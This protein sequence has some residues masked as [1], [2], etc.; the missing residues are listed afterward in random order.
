MLNEDRIDALAA[1]FLTLGRLHLDA[2]DEGT[3]AQ[4]RQ[5]YAQWPLAGSAS[6][7]TAAGLREWADSFDRGESADL[8]R[9]DINA[10]YGRTATALV[11]PFESVHRG[12]DGLVFD[13]ETLQV[14]GAYRQLGL[15]APYLHKEPDDHVGLEFDFVAQGLA[16][17]LS[18]LEVGA[19]TDAGRYF[20]VVGDFHRDHLALWAPEMLA[21][22]RDH[23]ATA[24][25]RGVA[26]L[27]LGALDELGAQFEQEKQL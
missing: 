25:Y 27:S 6:A 3:L 9:A 20:G 23:A 18:A 1:A 7:H 19:L 8:L 12:K 15:Q 21:A 11:A 2:P 26:A 22:A 13:E 16:R 14:R 24:F 4:L 10:L 17:T 5:M